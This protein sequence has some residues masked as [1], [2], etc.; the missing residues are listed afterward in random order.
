MK[1]IGIRDAYQM[2]EKFINLCENIRKRS[3]FTTEYALDD[4]DYL[5]ARFIHFD[6]EYIVTVLSL[7]ESDYEV[8]CGRYWT[9]SNIDNLETEFYSLVGRYVTGR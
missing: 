2:D 7:N 5:L 4:D 8:Q 6:D 3:T 1:E 9:H